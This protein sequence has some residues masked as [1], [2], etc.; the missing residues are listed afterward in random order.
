ME[1]DEDGDFW[2][3][4]WEDTDGPIDTQEM[5]EECP[6]GFAWNCC[7]QLGTAPGCTRGHHRAIEGKRM[8]T[9]TSAGSVSGGRK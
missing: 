6:D 4:H 1:V 7:N 8:K 9:S 3:D 5:R 2:A